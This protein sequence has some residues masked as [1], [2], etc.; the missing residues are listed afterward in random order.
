M[1]AIETFDGE[2]ED[3]L[4][5]RCEESIARRKQTKTALQKEVSFKL[6]GYR[7]EIEGSWA[8]LYSEALPDEPV[9]IFS[10]EKLS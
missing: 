1:D 7:Y 5:A 4:K 8:Y 3:L 2:P 10:C 6:S 9:E